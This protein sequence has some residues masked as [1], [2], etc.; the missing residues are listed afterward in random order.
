MKKKYNAKLKEWCWAWLFIA[1]TIIGL[2]VLNIIP[3]FKTAYLSFFKSGDFGRGNI[4]VKFDNY[5]KLFN[6]K[7]VWYALKNTLTYAAI[8][9][10][11]TIIIAL[12]LAALLNS[13]IKGK[14]FFRVVYFL[15]MI[16][17]PAA[18]TMV[19]KWLYNTQFGLFNYV[20]TNLGFDRVD[21][22][23]DPKTGLMCIITI[24]VWSDIGYSMILLLA[25]MQDIPKD[26]Y[27]AASIDGA[28]KVT[29]FFKI[30]IPLV[31]PTLYFVLVTSVIR[32]MQVFDIPYMMINF[33]SPAYDSSVSLV[34][35]FYNNSFVYN[36]KGYGSAIIM[37]LLVIILIITFLQNKLQKRWVNYM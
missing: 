3:I 18:V 33:A 36:N 14:S 17:I 19:W 22:L 2:I 10:P 8:E 26:F 12:C 7:Q 5:I 29:T 11:I 30:T 31:S 13:K 1:P 28:S 24:G 25:G 15:P 21:W 35:L 9:V 34:Y 20:L 4:F 16:A 6:D 37:L 32:A 23:N 27:E